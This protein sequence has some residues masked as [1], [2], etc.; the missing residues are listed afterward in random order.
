MTKFKKMEQKALI[1]GAF[2]HYNAQ[3]RIYWTGE[4]FTLDNCPLWVFVLHI[5]LIVHPLSIT[6]VFGVKPQ[7]H[8]KARR[9][10][11]KHLDIIMYK[12]LPNLN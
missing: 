10:K 5:V 8:N 9:I 4:I 3:Y 6:I 7:D 2:K 12:L 1:S 11:L